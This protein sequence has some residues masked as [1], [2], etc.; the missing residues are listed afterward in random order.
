MAYAVSAD[1]E[2][3]AGGS[4]KLIALADFD[5]SGAS[6]AGVVDAAI[7]EADALIN[8][9]AS[10]RFL[11]PFA[12][13]PSTINLLSARMAVRILRR[14]RGM[15][16]AQD[17]EDEKNDR[18]WL[19]DLSKGLVLPGVDPLPERGSIVVD[20]AVSDT[21]GNRETTRD[22]SREKLKGFW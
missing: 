8:S 17:V 15:T 3:A 11:V 4:A 10:K 16:L 21:A 9:Y 19:E 22:V 20:K 18:K 2:R 5:G 1:V 7:A 14:N 6:D 12:T 13:T